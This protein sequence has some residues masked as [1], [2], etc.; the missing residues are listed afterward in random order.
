[1]NFFDG[2]LFDEFGEHPGELKRK[3]VG[4]EGLEA[5][6]STCPWR[7]TDQAAIGV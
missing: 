1:M 5:R 6:L 2:S 4:R 7:I 3:F